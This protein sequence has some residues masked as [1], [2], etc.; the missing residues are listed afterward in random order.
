MILGPEEEEVSLKDLQK[1]TELLKDKGIL[2][3]CTVL[4][5]SYVMCVC[6]A[7]VVH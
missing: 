2:Y 1:F 7:L 5:A 4:A 3:W 6:V